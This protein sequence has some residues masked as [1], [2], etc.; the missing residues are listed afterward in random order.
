MKKM[1]L[2]LCS[3]F[4]GQSEAF[5]ES[6]A[7]FRIENNPLLSEVP[8]T[9]IADIFDIRPFNISSQRIDYVHASPPC[10]EFSLAYN[11]PR[12]RAERN[13]EDYHPTHGLAMAK[14]VK[15]I[16]DTLEP[17][18]WSVENVKGSAKYLSPIFG[19]PRLIVGAYVYYGNF[20]LFE[21]RHFA[22]LPSKADQDKRSK[23]P[24]RANHRA[25]IPLCSYHKAFFDAMEVSKVYF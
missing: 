18:Y 13:G 12:S 2:D 17:L 7:V 6:W 19:E 10:L 25:H 8:N 16:I 20:P 5:L 23:S 24:L 21:S 14:R 4:G 3:G 9:V 22:T 1:M 11:A 15:E